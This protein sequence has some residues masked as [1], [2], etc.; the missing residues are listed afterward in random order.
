[1]AAVVISDG[2]ANADI[3]FGEPTK[4]G[5]IVNNR[6]YE[7]GANTSTDGLSLFFFSSDRPGGVGGGLSD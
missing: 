4:L 5:P 2:N 1:V 7:F 3:T 6:Q